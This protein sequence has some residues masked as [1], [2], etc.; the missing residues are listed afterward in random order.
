MLCVVIAAVLDGDFRRRQNGNAVAV[1]EYAVTPANLAVAGRA[2]LDW[3]S[4]FVRLRDT[5]ESKIALHRPSDTQRHPFNTLLRTTKIF[6][7][8]MLSIID[9]A[10]KAP[11]IFIPPGDFASNT[12]VIKHAC[13]VSERTPEKGEQRSAMA[14]A[15][16]E[17]RK[18]R[19][20]DSIGKQTGFSIGILSDF[21]FAK[22]PPPWIMRYAGPL[23]LA[24]TLAC[25]GTTLRSLAPPPRGSVPIRSIVS[26]LCLM[27]GNPWPLILD[28]VA[29]KKLPA[30]FDTSAGDW[31]GGLKVVEFDVW[32][33]FCADLVP[34]TSTIDLPIEWRD[35]AFYL[36]FSRAAFYNR[37]S[38]FFAKRILTLRTLSQFRRRYITVQELRTLS[39]I[40][41]R[42]ISARQI[43]IEL[44]RLGIASSPDV[45][46]FYLRDA[47]SDAYRN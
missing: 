37:A 3:P 13:S 40:E 41:G 32:K 27:P 39:M 8:A 46:S 5:L 21:L 31:A 18:S 20:L 25:L 11:S 30:V 44:T 47:V 10:I 34:F 33:S 19:R 6:D 43:I 29:S 4:G 24:E 1:T 28:A 45:Q 26:A 12:T 14:K 42:Y 36:N 9:R 23:E 16:Q 35:A 38:P 15:T 2:V 7:K 17:I 22:N